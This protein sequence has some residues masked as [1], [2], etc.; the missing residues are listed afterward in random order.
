MGALKTL[1]RLSWEYKDSFDRLVGEIL[2]V[3]LYSG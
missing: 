1:G 2:L 3:C